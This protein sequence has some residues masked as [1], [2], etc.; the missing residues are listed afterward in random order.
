MFFLQVFVKL[1]LSYCTYIPAGYELNQRQQED[2]RLYS[3]RKV[4]SSVYTVYVGSVVNPDVLA[5]I[6]SLP[7][8]RI[9]ATFSADPELNIQ[10]KIVNKYV[11]FMF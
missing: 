2:S 7:V 6:Y 9:A 8:V 11:K 5:D 3:A 4:P 10:R 1:I